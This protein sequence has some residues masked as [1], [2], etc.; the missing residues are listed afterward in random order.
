MQTFFS[1]FPQINY[2]GRNVVDITKSINLDTNYLN[3][4]LSFNSYTLK[5]LDR[6]DLLSKKIY[7]DSYL[8]WLIFLSNQKIDPYDWYKDYDTFRDYLN[9]KYGDY[10]LAEKKIKYYINNWFNNSNTPISIAEFDTLLPNL[11]KYYFPIYDAN[12]NIVEYLRKEVDWFY[13]TNE[14]IKLYFNFNIPNTFINDEIVNITYDNG[15]YG[16]GQ[17]CYVDANSL[18]FQHTVGNSFPVNSIINAT[19]FSLYSQESNNTITIS[20]SNQIYVDIV[21]NIPDT[22]VVYYDAYTYYDYENEL[23]ESNKNIIMLDQNYGL[24]L[25]SELKNIFK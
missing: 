8:E 16:N 19:V 24:Q 9:Q 2:N 7:N 15:I 1:N 25:A 12:Y 5:D 13:N 14:V 3:N 22:E 6:S 11:N 18:Y 20:N 17:I 21:K 23:N 4:P 10:I